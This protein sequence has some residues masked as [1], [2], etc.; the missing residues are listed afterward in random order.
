M[1]EC[2]DN[3]KTNSNVSV[4]FNTT[5]EIITDNTLKTIIEIKETVLEELQQPINQQLTEP[6]KQQLMTG[7]DE[8]SLPTLFEDVI[9]INS[10]ENLLD[11]SVKPSVEPVI[12]FKTNLKAIIPIVNVK[13]EQNSFLIKIEQMVEYIKSTLG[14]NKITATNIIII[15]TNLMHIVEQ[16]KDLTGSQKK[17][18]ILDTLKK[19]INQNVSDVQERISLMMIVDMT[20]P[21]VLDT[22]VTAINGGLKFEKDKV[23]SGFKN[24]FCCVGSKTS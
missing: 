2:E 1:S 17:M 6:L 13:P 21:H 24:L 20:L 9:N 5:V 23:I 7:A 22:L 14:D 3:S 19:V 16:Y 18:L 12:N 15:T 10:L 4:S 8:V 11:P